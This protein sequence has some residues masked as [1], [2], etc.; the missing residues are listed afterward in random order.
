MTKCDLFLVFLVIGNWR[1]RITRQECKRWR[2][3]DWMC[4]E[5]ENL[6]L[7]ISGVLSRGPSPQAAEDS[8]MTF[9]AIGG[10]MALILILDTT[11]L[12]RA[13]S[14]TRKIL[15]NFQKILEK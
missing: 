15:R 4:G 5:A 13:L 11:R 2:N 9:A 12:L 8:Q 7:L 3:C 10:V 1:S 14:V 6:E